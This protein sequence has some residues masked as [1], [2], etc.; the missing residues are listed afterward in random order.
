[1]R[2]TTLRQPPITPEDHQKFRCSF[3][4]AGTLLF[5][6]GIMVTVSSEIFSKMTGDT[7][8]YKMACASGIG[9]FQVAGTRLL[10]RHIDRKAVNAGLIS[11]NLIALGLIATSRVP[12]FSFTAGAI[13]AAA[14]TGWIIAEQI[15]VRRL[16]E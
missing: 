3:W 6:A 1:M 15:K 13:A 16:I 9:L 10:D 2:P 5:T 4:T 8:L 11:G 14:F 12:T 7:S